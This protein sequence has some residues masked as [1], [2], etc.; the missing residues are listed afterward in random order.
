MYVVKDKGVELAFSYIFEK[1]GWVTT[2]TNINTITDTDKLDYAIQFIDPYY[3]E[4]GMLPF[5]ESMM[6]GNGYPNFFFSNA[7]VVTVGKR[8]ASMHD[9]RLPPARAG[10]A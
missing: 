8:W 7:L 2:K 5:A 9:D 1:D 10:G 3:F 6:R 4:F